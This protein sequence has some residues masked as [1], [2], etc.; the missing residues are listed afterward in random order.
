MEED[1]LTCLPMETQSIDLPMLRGLDLLYQLCS[2]ETETK[3]NNN[4]IKKKKN[5]NTIKLKT[6][7]S[8]KIS[9]DSNTDNS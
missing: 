7:T 6:K 1:P 5:R 3:R 4:T 9:A 2:S 8:I